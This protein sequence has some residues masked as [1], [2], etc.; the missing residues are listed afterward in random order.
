[1]PKLWNDTIT[2]HRQAVR[3]ALLDTTA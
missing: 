3:D 2:A 1:M